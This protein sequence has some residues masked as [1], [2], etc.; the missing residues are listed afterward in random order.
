MPTTTCARDGAAPA[1]ASN[2][3]TIATTTR[4]CTPCDL[5]VVIVLVRA[6]RALAL[7]RKCGDE[8]R[9]IADARSKLV[10]RLI[11]VTPGAAVPGRPCDTS[12][13]GRSAYGSQRAA[14]V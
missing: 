1:T 5:R 2:R 9:P 8:L 12:R 6:T 14:A 13:C 10:E 3:A 7:D 11:A 4:D